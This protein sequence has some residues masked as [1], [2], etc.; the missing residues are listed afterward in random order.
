MSKLSFKNLAII[1]GLH[2]L[3]F[4]VLADWEKGLDAYEK[5]DYETAIKEWERLASQGDADAQ[6]NLGHMYQSGL[7]VTQDFGMAIKWYILAAKQGDSEA[8]NNLGVMYE[9]GQGVEQNYE[10]SV[11]WYKLAAEKGNA[12][13]QNNLAFM[14]ANGQGIKTDYARGYMWWDISAALGHEKAKIGIADIEKEMPSYQIKEAKKLAQECI[15]R[16][17]RNC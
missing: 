14:Y 10:T 6:Y 11:K 3:C 13:A 8:Q 17:Y 15:A 4:P 7:G 2:L 16:N 5:G 9:S 12:K 1:F